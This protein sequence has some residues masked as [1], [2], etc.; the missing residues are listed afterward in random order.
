ML[1]ALILIKVFGLKKAL[2]GGVLLTA[3][4][5]LTIAAA[6]IGL[7]LQVITAADNAAIVAAAIFTSLLSPLAYKF[8]SQ[9]EDLYYS[10][11]IFGGSKASLLLAERM[12]MHDIPCL[13]IIQNQ[14]IIPDF[15]Q[16]NLNIWAVDE[17]DI[18]IFGE[19][20]IR[21]P[22]LVI[23]LTE[24]KK[25]NQ[26]LALYVKNKLNHS[27][28]ILRKQS[29]SHELVDTESD[30][31]LIDIDELLAGYVEDMIVRPETLTSLSESFGMYRI[32]EILL[33]RKELHRKQVMEVAFPLRVPGG[34]CAGMM[35][36][37]SHTE[38]HIYY[39]VTP[40]LS[41]ETVLHLQS[42]GIF[43]NKGMFRKIAV[44]L[45]LIILWETGIYF[46]VLNNTPEA[47]YQL[48]ARYSARTSFVLITIILLWIGATGLRKIYRSAFKRLHL[49]TLILLL[50]V[51]HLIHFGFLY[52]NLQPENFG[53]FLLENHLPAL[54]YVALMI[55]PWL[56]FSKKHSLHH[57]TGDIDLP[58]RSRNH[59]SP[60]LCGSPIQ[61]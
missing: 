55:S 49:I 1:P 43:W 47:L 53:K 39:W 44:L 60:D 61:P 40:S 12:K 46:W 34:P 45:M 51:N 50:A 24:S 20:D 48:S 28:I 19:L 8:F 10:I 7:S 57:S 30:L 52:A 36:S 59:L 25:L 21:T 35:K 38:T 56:L 2:A 58:D 15:E 13:T 26:Q 22:D 41:L 4:M 54:L 3:R 42:F 18:S 17:L 37:L 27:K 29:A 14:A 32:E 9:E 16:K 23:M 31:K 33:T 5:G 6:Q 11:Y